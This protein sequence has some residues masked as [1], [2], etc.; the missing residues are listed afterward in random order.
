[1]NET[2]GSV[3]GGAERTGTRPVLKDERRRFVVSDL[4]R[5]VH[6]VAVY[7]LTDRLVG[8]S[9]DT[10]REGTTNEFEATRRGLLEEHLPALVDAGLVERVDGER[11]ALT[12]AG[13]RA[14]AAVRDGDRE[15]E[16]RR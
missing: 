2:T 5:R 6:P 13:M 3:E 8:S 9:V 11:V 1:M 16:T 4:L 12:R 14:G 10:G 15:G 7:D